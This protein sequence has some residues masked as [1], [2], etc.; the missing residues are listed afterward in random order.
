MS[1]VYNRKTKKYEDITQYAGN[2][3]TKVY[4]NK[5]L[6]KIAT[7]KTVSNIYGI[8]NRLSISKRKIPKFIT[9]NNIDMSL[10]ENK[11]YKSF[12]EFFIRKYKKYNISKKGFISPCD[13]KLLVYKISDDLKINIKGITYTLNDLIDEELEDLK[14]G[15]LFVYRLSVDNYHRFHYIDDGS[16]IE[17]KRI[18][19]KLHT[20][21]DYSNKYKIYKENERVISFLST[22]NYGNIIYIE[23]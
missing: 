20:V 18:K 9:D 11:K 2:Y 7:S 17:S 21:S 13:S 4:N 10:Y 22:K 8:Y 6:L 16:L 15:Y 14:N 1:K 12:N 3:L 19:G 5:L 23:V